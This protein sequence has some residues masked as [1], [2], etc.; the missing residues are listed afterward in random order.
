MVAFRMNAG[1]L[2]ACHDG[3]VKA[4]R[5]LIATG[6]ADVFGTMN[7]MS[8]IELKFGVPDEATAAV[9]K[10]LR[11]LGARSL[12]IESRYRDSSDRRLAK[13]GLS[14]RLRKTSGRWEQTVKGPGAN[15]AERLEETVP[16]PGAW[17]ADGPSPDLSLHA[18]REAGALL[19]AALAPR[20][21]PPPALVPV[22]TSLVKRL[23]VHVEAAGADV[24]VAFD[25]GVIQA[26]EHS[27]PVSEVEVEL[28]RGDV[29]ALIGLG[30]ANVEAHGM[31][32]S[33][34]AKAM[35]GDRLAHAS[36]DGRAA[37]GAVKAKPAELRGV[38]DGDAI[39]R[40]VIRSCLDQVLAN[41]SV[42]AAGEVSDDAVHQLRVGL[43]RMRTA[44]RELGAWRGS[45]APGWEAP[46]AEVF[47]ALGDYRDRQ[48]IAAAMQKR[49][50]AAGSPDPALRPP[51]S[52]AAI[53]PVVLVRGKK[54]QQALLDVLAFVLEPAPAASFAVGSA[55]DDA[56]DDSKPERT[57][58]ARLDKLRTQLERAAKRFE[59]LDELERHRVRKRL[60][61]LRYL[62]ELVGPLYKTG[63][64]ERY[65]KSLEPAQDELGHYM[66][67]VVAARLA[68]DVVDGGDARAW[69]N[70]GWLKAQL[71][72]AVE[73]CRKV[74]QRAA[75]ARPFW[76]D[77]AS[78][79]S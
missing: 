48:T 77:A 64:V 18:D 13:A 25:R 35:R 79:R 1:M 51:P 6:R 27:T 37:T 11:R 2:K 54:F 52:G 66:D 39:F 41:A 58:G 24:E 78:Q 21:G 45:L 53:D 22:H 50:A 69:F 62:A 10:A 30:R 28:K 40:A 55:P 29:A 38:T 71:P 65:L 23:A 57:I 3:G 36:S 5:R 59:R 61:R 7:R 42:I 4:A 31:W 47:R 75:A 26:G 14:L 49:L 34:L 56:A 15:A 68:H 60:K 32:L 46:A 20:G 63:R 33:T 17:N 44:W 19:D 70:V 9:E 12:T 73:R 16:R 43:R 67:L 72:Q 76:R 8:E 74:L